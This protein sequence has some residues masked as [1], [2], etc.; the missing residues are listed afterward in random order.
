MNEIVVTMT[1]GE[2]LE[3]KCQVSAQAN[4]LRVLISDGYE[5]QAWKALGYK[6]WTEC[7]HAISEEFNLSESYIW[8]LQ[9]ANKVEKLLDYSPVGTI[10]ETQLRPLTHL[11]PEQQREAWQLAIESAPGGKITA[12][13]VLAAA[14]VI[15]RE[16]QAERR[17]EQIAET[18]TVPDGK[19]N[20]IYADPPWQYTFG[21]D[22]HG[23]ADRHYATMSIDDLCNLPIRDLAEDNAVLFLWTT[24]PKLFDAHDVIKAWGF[25]YKT[26]FVWDKVKHVMGHYNSVRHEF[27]LLCIKGSFPKQSDTLH[28]SVIEIERSDEHSEKPEYFRQLI[29]TMYPLSKKIELFA[30][31]KS[32]GWDAWGNE[33]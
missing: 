13:V 21:F 32:E 31:R 1:E 3:W 27:L 10:P 26:S 2:A 33:L 18:P 9:A 6:N 28:D 14:R 29:E 17:Q 23:A 20:V 12:A 7:V 22:I 16:K 19:F 15:N 5:R 30:R 24:S 4:N 25:E 11:E 8:K